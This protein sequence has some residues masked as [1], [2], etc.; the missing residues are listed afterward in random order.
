MY[1][2]ILLGIC[3]E[4]DCKIPYLAANEYSSIQ[5]NILC[6]KT[7]R[8]HI[9][10]KNCYENQGP[11]GITY[12]TNNIA[13]ITYQYIQYALYLRENRIDVFTREIDTVFFTLF[14]IPLSIMLAVNG[15]L[16]FHAGA[17]YI[18][19]TISSFTA[20][21]GK[22][23]STLILK[24]MKMGLKIYSDDCIAILNEDGHCFNSYSYLKVKKEDIQY[25]PF[26]V[27]TSYYNESTN[28][29]HCPIPI[30]PRQELLT[31][32][33]ILRRENC[34]EYNLVD[35]EKKTDKVLALFNGIVGIRFYNSFLKTQIINNPIFIKLVD[36]VTFRYLYIPN[37]SFNNSTLSKIVNYL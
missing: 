3:L 1:K 28:K 35:I 33:Y 29:Y 17:C 18:N 11:Y 25:V 36:R 31:K 4:S 15:L 9:E 8:I 10:E 32:I 30:L 24:L 16:M 5:S 26:D 34:D 20:E 13:I 23:K 14:H 6:T 7:I 22:G 21:K 37:E 19:G 2:Y 12:P 27:P